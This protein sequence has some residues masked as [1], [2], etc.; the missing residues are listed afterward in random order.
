MVCLTFENVIKK[1]S[2]K[3]TL[4]FFLSILSISHYVKI[5]KLKLSN[6]FIFNPKNAIFYPYVESFRRIAQNVKNVNSQILS[7]ID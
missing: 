5:V 3:K 4:P 1:S 2:H 7:N 6:F